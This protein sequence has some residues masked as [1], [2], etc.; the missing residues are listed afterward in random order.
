MSHVIIIP[1]TLIVLKDTTEI[2]KESDES[3]K[4]EVN[5]ISKGW[6]TRVSLNTIS[7]VY[8][9]F[10]NLLSFKYSDTL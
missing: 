9:G 7:N 3:F 1:I 2:H 5:F 4:Y 8:E 10:C 6:T